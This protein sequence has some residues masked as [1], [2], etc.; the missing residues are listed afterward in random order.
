MMRSIF[1]ILLV[2]AVATIFSVKVV[3]NRQFESFLQVSKQLKELN[4]T[5]RKLKAQI[6]YIK[7]E[8]ML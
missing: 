5:N 1:E 3:E 8:L 7:R 4:K 6:K 2:M